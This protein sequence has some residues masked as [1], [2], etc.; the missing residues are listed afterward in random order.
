[1][2]SNRTTSIFV[3]TLCSMSQKK[4]P[5]LLVSQDLLSIGNLS[6][7]HAR[8]RESS[9]LARLRRGRCYRWRSG[10]WLI[11]NRWRSRLQ[12]YGLLHVIYNG[13]IRRGYLSHDGIDFSNVDNPLLLL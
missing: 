8:N 13:W 11:L 5:L 1:M 7:S 2:G 3:L 10:C 4:Q 9:I 12:R 6:P